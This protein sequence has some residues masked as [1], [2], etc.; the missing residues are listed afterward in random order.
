[1]ILFLLSLPLSLSLSSLLAWN[2]FIYNTAYHI[3]FY[4]SSEF[5]QRPRNVLFTDTMYVLNISIAYGYGIHLPDPKV[6]NT[7]LF[8]LSISI[9]HTI[10]F[11]IAVS[12]KATIL[13]VVITNL[14][15]VEVLGI[16]S[17]YLVEWK[18]QSYHSISE[19]ERQRLIKCFKKLFIST[20]NYFVLFQYLSYIRTS[21][22]LFLLSFLIGYR[23][24]WFVNEFKMIRTDIGIVR[25]YTKLLSNV[26]LMVECEDCSKCA[27]C[28]D[29][30]D[31]TSRKL[32]CDHIFHL[33]CL[34]ALVNKS[35]QIDATFHELKPSFLCPIC[36]DKWNAN[37]K[38][39]QES[40][41]DDF[42]EETK[43]FLS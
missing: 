36:K 11:M 13:V 26:E 21:K 14:P 29:T 10:L 31:M 17:L 2:K 27:I 33:N 19:I 20:L 22:F 6:S 30:H 25:K 28:L 39:R 3:L 16:S 42:S 4:N 9:V 34:S 23:V 37:K 38:K 5:Y 41:I 7:S 24:V 43:D 1:M 15:A 40:K 35:G 18:L 32:N 8:F 12:F